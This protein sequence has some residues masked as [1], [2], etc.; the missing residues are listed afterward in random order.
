MVLGITAGYWRTE[1]GKWAIF[2]SSLC[3][4]REGIRLRPRERL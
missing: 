2:K 3:P 4:Y 1:E